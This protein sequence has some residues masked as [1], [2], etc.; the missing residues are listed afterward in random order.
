MAGVLEMAW[1]S[2]KSYHEGYAKFKVTVYYIVGVCA[3]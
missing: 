2:G 3:A 1:R